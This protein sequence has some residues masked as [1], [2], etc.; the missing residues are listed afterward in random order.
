[1]M[2]SPSKL[3]VT[4]DLRFCPT[5]SRFMGEQEVCATCEMLAIPHPQAWDARL[6][7]WLMAEHWRLKLETVTPA[8]LR[9][10]LLLSACRGRTVGGT[11]HPWTA[12]P[13]DLYPYALR[14]ALE[15]FPLPEKKDAD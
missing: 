8:Q 9:V 13:P 10:D 3:A 1:M 11:R 14:A 2:T 15:A 5:C 12:T 7:K 6:V 4:Q